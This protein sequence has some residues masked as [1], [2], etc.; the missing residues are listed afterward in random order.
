MICFP[1][2]TDSSIDEDAQASL[3]NLKSRYLPSVIGE[4][5][6][7]RFTLP[8]T[9]SGIDPTHPTIAQ[10]LDDICNIFRDRI[11]GMIDRSLEQRPK[12]ADQAMADVY[13]E[14]LHHAK[15]C[16]TKCR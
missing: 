1:F 7:H 3:E 14:V 12:V 8:W 15:F 13:E 10:Y 9:P 11:R 4:D 6:I 2:F 5:F 16:E